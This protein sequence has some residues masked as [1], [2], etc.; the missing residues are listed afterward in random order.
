[1]KNPD[2]TTWTLD[3]LLK[4]HSFGNGR[5]GD[6]PLFTGKQVLGLLLAVQKDPTTVKKFADSIR[7]F[8]DNLPV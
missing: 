1:M 8:Y 4:P 3:Q 2:L 7:N 5:W 6:V